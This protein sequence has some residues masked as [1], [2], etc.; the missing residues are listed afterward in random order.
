MASHGRRPDGA[1]FHDV[2]MF[3][4]G[5]LH[6]RNSVSAI[7]THEMHDLRSVKRT[8]LTVRVLVPTTANQCVEDPK[9]DVHDIPVS[10]ARSQ[11]CNLP[12]RSP[13]GEHSNLRNTLAVR[14]QHFRLAGTCPQEKV[15]RS[16]PKSF[17]V[18]S[19][20][21]TNYRLVTMSPSANA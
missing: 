9:K 12:D 17:L 1:F 18:L 21:V 2:T 19:P 4:G 10:A 3:F 5:S 15:F 8:A 6:G 16:D 11:S 20:L 7:F 14:L 13:A